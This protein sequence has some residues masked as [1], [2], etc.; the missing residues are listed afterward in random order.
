[1]FS[2]YTYFPNPHVKIKADTLSQPKGDVNGIK[3]SKRSNRGIDVFPRLRQPKPSVLGPSTLKHDE[4]KI[5]S[6][7]TI[8]K[9]T[10]K[11]K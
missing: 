4:K 9:S 1:M 5:I 6:G 10:K 11:K 3:V 7:S 8:K 2:Y